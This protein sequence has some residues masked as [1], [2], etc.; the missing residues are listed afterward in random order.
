MW[1]FNTFYKNVKK[2]DHESTLYRTDFDELGA[3]WELR[4]SAFKRHQNHQNRRNIRS[5]HGQL[6]ILVHFCTI[7]GAFFAIFNILKSVKNV[8]KSKHGH[9]STLYCSVFDDFSVVWKLTI[10]ALKRRQA[11]QNPLGIRSIRGHALIWKSRFCILHICL[12]FW[13]P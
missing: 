8:R 2:W 12:N 9:E 4:P 6:L 3:V 1:V 10:S 13:P 7:F 11:R 5:I